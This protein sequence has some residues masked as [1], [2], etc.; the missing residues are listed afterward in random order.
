MLELV[1]WKVACVI[2]IK[3]KVNFKLNNNAMEKEISSWFSLLTIKYTNFF[4][5]TL[6]WRRQQ[7]LC[8]MKIN[9]RV[10]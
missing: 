3:R 2:R 9:G 4:S 1:M 5:P 7:F 10:I 6:M 8:N